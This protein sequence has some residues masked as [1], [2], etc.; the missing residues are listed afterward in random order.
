MLLLDGTLQS[1]FTNESAYLSNL[2][3][4]CRS[5]GGVFLSALAKTSNM[6]T[7]TGVPLYH[8]VS[9]AERQSLV[10]PPVVHASGRHLLQGP[11]GEDARC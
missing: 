7:D 4:R 5:R 9:T 1:T 3:S 6:V 10:R 8:A 11:Q 2:V